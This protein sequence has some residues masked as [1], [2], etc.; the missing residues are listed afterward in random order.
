MFDDQLMVTLKVF[1]LKSI[2]KA[3]IKKLSQS[4]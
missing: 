2:I 3:T 1:E 4:I